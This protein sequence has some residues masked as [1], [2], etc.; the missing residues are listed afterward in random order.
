MGVLVGD[1]QYIRGAV[2]DIA[3]GDLAA[4]PRDLPTSE[5]AQARLQ[6]LPFSPATRLIP[7]LSGHYPRLSRNQPHRISTL[8]LNGLWPQF[9]RPPSSLDHPAIGQEVGRSQRQLPLRR[10]SHQRS[11]TKLAFLSER[12]VKDCRAPLKS[13]V[14][15]LIEAKP[16]SLPMTGSLPTP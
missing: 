6:I 9:Y 15:R 14:P 4:L 3:R 11:S 12:V 7:L 5:D 13:V 10:L 2:F 16:L 8:C 1:P